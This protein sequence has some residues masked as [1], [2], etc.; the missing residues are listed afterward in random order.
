MSV[1]EKQTHIRRAFPLLSLEQVS[2]NLEGLVHEVISVNRERVFRF[3]GG[4]WGR[5]SMSSVTPI[6]IGRIGPGLRSTSGWERGIFCRLAPRFERVERFYSA[7]A[8]PIGR[9]GGKQER[10]E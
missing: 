1:E 10:E 8:P 2:Y 5:E 9:G 7:A 3:P 6:K 4:A